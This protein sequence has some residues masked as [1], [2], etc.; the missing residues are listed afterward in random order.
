MVVAVQGVGVVLVDAEVSPLHKDVV[1][2][3]DVVANLLHRQLYCVI[4]VMEPDTSHVSVPHLDLLPK[5][6]L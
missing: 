3:L 4:I 5:L 1:I 6:I 2:T